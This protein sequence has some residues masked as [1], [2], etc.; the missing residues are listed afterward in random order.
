MKFP[1]KNTHEREESFCSCHLCRLACLTRLWN[2][3]ALVCYVIL[4]EG[5]LN[6]LPVALTKVGGAE[7]VMPPNP[8]RLVSFVGLVGWQ[9]S[10]PNNP[11]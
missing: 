4:V 5:F 8:A 9:I 3:P 2:F 10:Q 1:K 6:S 7:A 11:G